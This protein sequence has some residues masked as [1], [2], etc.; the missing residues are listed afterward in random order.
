MADAGFE[1]APE[2]PEK[3]SEPAAPELAEPSP[4][5]SASLPDWMAD[6]DSPPA[7]SSTPAAQAE[8]EGSDEE[9]PDWLHSF[10][11][12]KPE[13]EP[14]SDELSGVLAALQPDEQETPAEPSEEEPSPVP[15]AEVE[16]SSWLENIIPG[17]GEPSD[18]A[19]EKEPASPAEQ[20][21][22]EDWIASLG[23]G[24]LEQA[25]PSEPSDDLPVP[26]SEVPEPAALPEETKH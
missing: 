10:E 12:L 11:A 24:A 1:E 3:P 2:T 21:E 6:F 8:V 7:D 14:T 17:A 16:D 20:P 23:L 4:T 9:L 22:G 19:P 5:P 25:P 18:P 15:E 26:S 13:P